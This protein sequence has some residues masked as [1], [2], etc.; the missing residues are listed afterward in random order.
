MVKARNFHMIP[1]LLPGNFAKQ[2]VSSVPGENTVG[3]FVRYLDPEGQPVPDPHRLHLL[4][5]SVQDTDPN[6][7]INQIFIKSIIEINQCILSI[8]L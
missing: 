6:Q 8:N 5:R 4:A 2:Y 3:R 7:S 1:W